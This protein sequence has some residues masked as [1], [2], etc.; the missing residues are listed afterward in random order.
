[1]DKQNNQPNILFLRDDDE[2]DPHHQLFIAVEQALML[3]SNNLVTA[4]FLGV[5]AHYLEYH[6]KI[7]DF[8]LF[9]QGRVLNVPSKPGTKRH[10]SSSSHFAGIGREYEKLSD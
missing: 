10:P 9:L 4:I 2:D 6:P 1:M 7:R 5:V 3:E 8:W